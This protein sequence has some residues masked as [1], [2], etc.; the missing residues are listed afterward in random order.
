MRTQHQHHHHALHCSVTRPAATGG[1]VIIWTSHHQVTWV[2]RVPGRQQHRNRN[3]T[4]PTGIHRRSGT[5]GHHRLVTGVES[6]AIDHAAARRARAPDRQSLTG[7]PTDRHRAPVDSIVIS[8]QRRRQRRRRPTGHRTIRS[9]QPIDHHRSADMRQLALLALSPQLMDGGRVI[10]CLDR[11][12]TTDIVPLIP[13]KST[14]GSNCYR[15][16]RYPEGT[17]SQIGVGSTSS[18]WTGDWHR[19]WTWTSSWIH[20]SS[21]THSIYHWSSDQSEL[22]LDWRTNL[23]T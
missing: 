20:R 16:Y 21:V 23:T 3:R 4:S 12:T 9:A 18:P 17:T 1:I 2:S 15:I 11:S 7:R 14:T 13:Y 19:T 8:E 10:C 5:C 22:A 6:A